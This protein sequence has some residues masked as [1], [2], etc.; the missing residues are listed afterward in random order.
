[1]SL[2]DRGSDMPERPRF[3][4]RHPALVVTSV[5]VVLPLIIVAF[6][7]VVLYN[8]SCGDN[9]PG[10]NVA[11]GPAV[12]SRAP[13]DETFYDN[14]TVTLSSATVEV[15][16]CIPSPTTTYRVSTAD[17]TVDVFTRTTGDLARAS[18]ACQPPENFSSCTASQGGWYA[19]LF[20]A[21]AH[22][23]STFPTTPSADTWSELVYPGTQV[24]RLCIVSP[25][26]LNDTGTQVDFQGGPFL[27]IG[28]G[29][30]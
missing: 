1:M 15:G 4:K 14:L 24:E 22:L 10:D 9:Q 11:F 30:L 20:N 27:I 3:R 16:G 13:D 12:P 29:S 25:S 23:Q 19:A 8:T 17:F 18:A 26:D 7:Y 28:V 21:S 2:E 5:L 6:L